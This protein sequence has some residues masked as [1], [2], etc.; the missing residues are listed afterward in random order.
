LLSQQAEACNALSKKLEDL[1]VDFKATE[2]D[3]LALSK[4]IKFRNKIKKDAVN[5][6][7]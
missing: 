6:S 4:K 3:I 2:L 5:V 1:Q 7:L